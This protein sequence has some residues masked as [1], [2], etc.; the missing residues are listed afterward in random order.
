MGPMS[1][2]GTSEV[3]EGDRRVIVGMRTC[4]KVS[5]PLLL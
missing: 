2:Q 5:T 4:D 1:S 3:K